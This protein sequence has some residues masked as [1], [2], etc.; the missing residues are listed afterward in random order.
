MNL[1]L[2]SFAIFSFSTQISPP[3]LSR[4]FIFSPLPQRML[5]AEIWTRLP[6]VSCVMFTVSWSIILLLCP[7]YPRFYRGFEV[8]FCTT[9]VRIHT[10]G[11]LL[12]RTHSPILSLPSALSSRHRSVFSVTNHVFHNQNYLYLQMDVCVV[13]VN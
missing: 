2:I 12:C 3:R 6:F 9:V 5:S 11:L 8:L 1:D 10:Q 7:P 4:L 13:C